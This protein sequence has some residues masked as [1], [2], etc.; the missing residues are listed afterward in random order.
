MSITVSDLL[1]VISQDIDAKIKRE[2]QIVYGND[3]HWTEEEMSYIDGLVDMSEIVE[4][5]LYEWEQIQESYGNGE[6]E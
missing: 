2:T 3:G 1:R 4:R 5:R 6:F